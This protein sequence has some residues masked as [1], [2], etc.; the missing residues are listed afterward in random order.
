MNEIFGEIKK[1]SRWLVQRPKKITHLGAAVLFPRP[2]VKTS[3]RIF[4]RYPLALLCSIVLLAYG[5]G[6]R[7]AVPGNIPAEFS[8]NNGSASYSVPIDVAPGRGGMQPEL[9][10]NYSSNGGNGILGVGW[11]LGGLSAISRCGRTVAQDGAVSGINFDKND[12]YCLDGQRLVPVKGANGAV[13]AEYRTEIDS[14]AKITSHGGSTNKPN[15]WVVKTKAGQVMTYGQ[16]GNSTHTFSQGPMSWAIREANDTTGKNPVTYHYSINSYKQYLNRIS[17]AGGNVEF[18]YE[19]TTARQSFFKGQAITANKRLVSISTFVNNSSVLNE[20]TFDYDIVGADKRSQLK[21]LHQCDD[22]NRC[23]K[24]LKFEWGDTVAS[25]NQLSNSAAWVGGGSGSDKAQFHFGDFNGDGLTDHFYHRYDAYDGKLRLYLGQTNGSFKYKTAISGSKSAKTVF[26]FSDYN[27]DGIADNIYHNY[28]YEDGKLRVRLGRGDGTFGAYKLAGGGSASS[29]TKF[30]FNDYDGDGILDYIY[31]NYDASEGQFKLYLGKGD[32]TFKYKTAYSGSKS[33]KTVF[34]FGDYNGDGII[35]NLYHNHDY[36]D[37]KFRVRLGKGDGTFGSFKF[38]GGGSTSTKTKFYFD[39]YNNDGILDHTYHK[40]DSNEG[41]LRVF[42]GK[43]DG[44]FKL[45]HTISGSTSTKTNFYFG[46]F[47]GDGITDNIYHNYDYADGKLRL[48]LGKGDGSYT[49]YVW[50]GSGS[51]WPKADF[52]FGDYNGDGMVDHIQHLYDYDGGPL[53]VRLNKG[54]LLHNKIVK[55]TDSSTNETQ[56]SYKSLSSSTVYSKGTGAT[57]PLIDI[58]TPIQVVSRVRSDAGIGS[59]TNIVDYTYK[60]LKLHAHGRGVLGFRQITASYPDTGKEERSYYKFG[61]YPIL[62]VLEKVEERHKSRLINTKDN[63]YISRK[64]GKVFELIMDRSIDKSYELTG[65]T[66]PVTT[67]TTWYQNFDVFGNPRRVVVSTAADGQDFRK[68][69]DSVYTN[70]T[71]KWHLGRL[72][73]NITTHRSPG[74]PD[75]KRRVDFKYNAQG[76]LSEE[77]VVSAA[78][79]ATWLTRT[80]H[81]Y[82]SFGQKT[83]TTTSAPGQQNRITTYSRDGLQRLQKVCNAYNECSTNTYDSK[84]RLASTTGANGLKTS[85]QYDGLGRQT[86]ENRADGTW[87][88]TAYG[89]ANQGMCR[90]NND[91][92][93]DTAYTCVVSQTKGS[94][95]AVVQLDKFGRTVRTVKKGFDGRLSYSDTEYDRFGRVTRVSRDYYAGDYVYWATSQYDALDRVKKVTQPG[96]HGSAVE[97]TTWYNGLRINTY[98]GPQTRGR[99][100]YSN[101]LGKTTKVEEPTGATVDYTHY[102]DGSLKSTRVNGDNTTRITLKYDEFGRKIESKDPSLGTWKYQYN[103]FGELTKQTNAKNQVSTLAYDKLGRL[104]K[105]V[106]PEGTSTWVYSSISA[107]KGSRGKLT[108]EKAPGITRD[109][110]YDSLGRSDSI[111]TTISGAGTFTAET[112]YDSNG[113]VKRT[114]YP[115]S[116][117]FFT[118][119]LYN[120]HGYLSTVRGLRKSAESHDY[121]QLTPLISKAV[122]TANEYEIRARKLR[123]IGSYYQSKIDYYQN[124]SG[125]GKA[126]TALKTQLNA[127][128]TQ[129]NTISSQGKAL[130]PKFMGHLNQ[131]LDELKAVNAL[132]TAQSQSYKNIAAQLAVLAEQT[133]AAADHQYQYARTYDTAAAAY[134]S[135]D[136]TPTGTSGWINYWKALQVDASGRMAAEVYGNGIVNDYTYNQGRYS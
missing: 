29:K 71:A 12:R 89:F 99:A 113:R 13:G 73:R 134:N 19:T 70:D 10:I 35:D 6:V 126:N 90:P 66:T 103:G 24:P 65:P 55:I 77:K 136:N 88:T 76:L 56:L 57:F 82:N 119:N 85:W 79:P 14:Y 38:S 63:R 78:N 132:I 58:A 5:S 96:T 121:R 30:H 59:S 94:P 1:V 95:K 72:T 33:S 64:N 100:V 108:Q 105:R 97:V 52:Y 44:T 93:I 133:L 127:H 61:T 37:G 41:K 109:F 48:R 75:Q 4:V 116:S 25:S 18:G 45:A 28:D 11:S 36:E 81:A 54:S 39:D 124:L 86:R 42:L 118:E 60:G 87:T 2:F 102:S 20:F 15:Y 92:I 120:S 129:L 114:T 83:K 101:A 111:S 50:S 80:Q 23:L 3:S 67:V 51:K 40:Y 112:S 34:Y 9:S 32:G 91:S 62:G 21:A 122:S 130:S 98:S 117:G 131:T 31:H 106:E 17:Y 22:S 53:R 104:V 135:M 8:V 128:K 123:Q 26:Y 84:S 43:G 107:P 125:S 47:N 74:N 49:G 7:A 46:D 68:Y 115:G 27:G 16:G 69:T 110:S